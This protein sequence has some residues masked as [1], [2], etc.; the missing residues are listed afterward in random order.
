ME[1]ETS[2][3]G[4]EKAASKTLSWPSTLGVLGRHSPLDIVSH[5]TQQSID[6]TLHTAVALATLLTHWPSSTVCRVGVLEAR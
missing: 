3:H 1:R 4:L 5:C 6:S 2:A